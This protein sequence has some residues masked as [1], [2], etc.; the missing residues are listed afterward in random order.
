VSLEG[1]L[2]GIFN[3]NKDKSA[4]IKVLMQE[5]IGESFRL[6]WFESFEFGQEFEEVCIDWSTKI[7]PLWTLI[8][9]SLS[10]DSSFDLPFV[11]HCLLL[12]AL[13]SSATTTTTC[14]RILSAETFEP[15]TD[16]Q[17]S[18]HVIYNKSCVKSP[19]WTL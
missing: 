12:Q 13:L 10:F 17:T 11:F 3:S 4:G 9:N 19:P 6:D 8:S 1:V 16:Y 7:A 15:W 18:Q 5:K 2:A 14:F